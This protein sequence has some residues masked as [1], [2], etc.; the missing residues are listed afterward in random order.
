MS[1]HFGVF[2]ISSLKIVLSYF[3]M[4]NQAT[5]KTALKDYCLI[6]CPW[7]NKLWRWGL[8]EGGLLGRVLHKS[9]SKGV[10]AAGLDRELDWDAGTAETSA[11]PRGAM[12]VKFHWPKPDYQ[13]FLQQKKRKRK[14]GY[15][16][17]AKYLNTGNGGGGGGGG[18]GVVLAN[19]A[20]HMQV[21]ACQGQENSFIEGKRKFGGL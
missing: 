14:K 20:S 1:L 12:A 16:I 4:K 10:R 2:E 18:V 17:S 13:L 7:E 21:P 8:C 11:N 19:L 6:L 15:L 9:S 3:T 5:E